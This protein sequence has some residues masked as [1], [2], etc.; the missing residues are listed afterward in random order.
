M[1]QD[2]SVPEAGGARAV[3]RGGRVG[4][5]GGTVQMSDSQEYGHPRVVRGGKDLR[6][7]QRSMIRTPLE[8]AVD[9]RYRRRFVK[10]VQDRPAPSRAVQAIVQGDQKPWTSTVR[11][12]LELRA[13]E[14]P[15]RIAREVLV[16]ET[17]I[18]LDELY[19][20]LPDAA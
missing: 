9:D 16:E 14:V 19:S 10:L 1:T 15:K 2:R 13:A 6:G 17:E 18:L 8:L 5:I 4:S 20:D 3:G 11:R 12:A 7:R